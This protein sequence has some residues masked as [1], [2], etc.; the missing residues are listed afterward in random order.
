MIKLKRYYWN[1]NKFTENISII[2]VTG[3]LIYC[4]L[5]YIITIIYYIRLY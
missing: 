2:I 1:I 4:F 5:K 3:S